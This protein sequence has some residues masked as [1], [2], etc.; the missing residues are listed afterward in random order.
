MLLLSIVAF[1]VLVFSLYSIVT[2]LLS[3]KVKYPSRVFKPLKGLVKW[4]LIYL[5]KYFSSL[6]TSIGFS[7]PNEE[8][9]K[10]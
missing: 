10:V 5:F 2:L 3:T 8:I 6:D 9:S 1:I 4:T 7:I